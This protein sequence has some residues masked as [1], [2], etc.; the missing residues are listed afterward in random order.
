MKKV[1]E[2]LGAKAKAREVGRA[3]LG[4]LGR[5]LSPELLEMGGEVRDIMTARVATCSN[6]DSLHRAA[7]IMW[8]RDC[9]VV[10]VVEAE[11]R[12][13]GVVTDRDLCM[14]AY[15]QGRTLAAIGIA[16]MLSGRL[17]ACAPG[18]SIDEA[19]ALMR[20]HRVRRL[21]VLE[22]KQKLAGVVSLADVARHVS[23]LSSSRPELALVLSQ[24]MASLSER[25]P[26]GGSA[27]RAAE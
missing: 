2:D 23:N 12:V 27:D 26:R 7:Q 15:T 24:L 14:A 20:A 10:P 11:G 21:V 8:E 6:T 5:R 1:L 3:V 22:S 16:S 18:D 4:Y 13:V 9:G 17:H 25:R 19:I